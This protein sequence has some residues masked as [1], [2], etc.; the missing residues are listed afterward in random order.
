MIADV[1]VAGA[2]LRDV[3][4]EEVAAAAAGL[5]GGAGAVRATAIKA[6]LSDT[7]VRC[8]L[9][10]WLHRWWPSAPGRAGGTLP[11]VDRSLLEIELG[12]LV[13]YAESAF[14]TAAPSQELLGPHLA[15]L[16]ALVESGRAH[17]VGWRGQLSS[18]ALRTALEAAVDCVP[19]ELP[20][21]AE[22][23]ALLE[24]IE[25]EEAVLAAE[26]GD[27]GW[28]A[29]LAHA[30]EHA[31][32]P[33]SRRAGAARARH[34]HPLADEL[35]QDEEHLAH[36]R[37]TVDEE[38]V[39]PGLYSTAE[40]N[41]QWVVFVRDGT[42]RVRVAAEA[43]RSLLE[44]PA[45]LQLARVVPTPGAAPSSCARRTP[46]AGSP[47][48]RPW[49]THRPTSPSSAPTSPPRCSR[50]RPTSR[51]TLT[52]AAGPGWTSATATSASSGSSPSAAAGPGRA[53]PRTQRGR[54]W[55]SSSPWP[56]SGE[57]DPL[58][59]LPRR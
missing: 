1:Q 2:W 42:T 20:G 26:V 48:R 7:V 51:R 3:Y 44:P 19:E 9:G 29:L 33:V 34:G 54:G 6:F 45:E 12:G 46:P 31:L 27:P 39:S 4:G 16:A 41:G 24:R 22:C 59:R 43:A 10:M 38:L 35:A 17:D 36:G 23:A 11:E 21:Y 47:A 13:W 58:P 28:R 57:R 40:D 52:P 32:K 5:D 56:T 49:A 14:G 30:R 37:F 18:R 25:A 50:P 55:P 15:Q 8:G 53:T